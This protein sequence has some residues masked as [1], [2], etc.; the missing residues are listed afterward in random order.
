MTLV[1]ENTQLRADLEAERALVQV[2]RNQPSTRATRSD[3]DTLPGIG[4]P[5]RYRG[6]ARRAGR[7]RGRLGPAKWAALALLVLGIA[8]ELAAGRYPGL[9]GPIQFATDV[10]QQLS[11]GSP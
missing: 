10:L 3:E 11:G 2:L 1:G 8:A 9:V 4:M 7:S 6:K 5:Q